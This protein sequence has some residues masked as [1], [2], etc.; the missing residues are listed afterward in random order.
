[1]SY[2]GAGQTGYGGQGTYG[3][4]GYNGYTGGA[5]SANS[6]EFNQQQNPGFY[7]GN[8]GYQGY[9]DQQQS[10]GP[11]TGQNEW[12]SGDTGMDMGQTGGGYPSQMNPNG[13]TPAAQQQNNTFT[14]H[15][16]GTPAPEPMQN[17]ISGT[18]GGGSGPG[19]YDDEPPL[20]EE[21][22]INFD[23]IKTK[24]I[25]VLIPTRAIEHD[26]LNDT[27]MAGP[28]VFCLLQGFCLM[29]SGKLF[30]GY[31]FGF[32]VVGCVA[33]YSVINLMNHATNSTIDIYRVF[34]VLGYC[35]L[36]IVLLSAVTVLINLR[37]LAWLG[38]PLTLVAVLWS[39][40][41]ATRFFEAATLMREQRWLIAYP[42]FL[43]YA[44]F[45][46]IT[47]F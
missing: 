29:F 46:L 39:T 1:M 15:G 34:S 8:Q 47:V 22:G 38:T 12:F 11:Q 33:M 40:Q 35:L 3:G 14:S 13:F 19:N 20:L 21:L 27:D 24:T 43:L 5:A 31:V 9:Q 25:A 44:C 42:V 37:D 36:P 23:H 2:E 16:F 18:V 28:L 17:T 6:N 45:A 32:G 4:Q 7:Q 30:F 26:M 41:T 10:Q